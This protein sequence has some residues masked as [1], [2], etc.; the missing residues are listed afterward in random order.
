MTGKYEAKI[1]LQLPLKCQE[2]RK[3]RPESV[4][5]TIGEWTVPRSKHNHGSI[6]IGSKMIMG[7]KDSNN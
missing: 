4:V 7:L 2:E 3:N 1:L 5:R 6:M